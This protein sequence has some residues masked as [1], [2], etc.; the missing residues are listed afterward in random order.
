M[1]TKSTKP[2]IRIHDLTTNEVIDREM[3]DAEFDQ[4]KLDQ[5]EQAA[6]KAET[7]AKAEARQA[8]LDRL[9]LSADEVKLLLG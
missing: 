7:E 8:V 5:A 1:M 9:G 6:K 4:Y 3:T 2:M